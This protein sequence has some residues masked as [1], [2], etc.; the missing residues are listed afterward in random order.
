MALPLTFIGLFINQ[1]SVIIFKFILA[2]I[3]LQ[4]NYPYLHSNHE[5]VDSLQEVRA[6]SWNKQ[7]IASN[8]IRYHKSQANSKIGSFK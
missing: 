1:N 4:L 6:Y 3:F 5:E 2:V 7:E 8:A